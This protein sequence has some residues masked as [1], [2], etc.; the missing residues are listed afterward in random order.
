MSDEVAEVK[1][2]AKAIVKR[3]DSGE[4]VATS[5]TH[6]LEVANILEASMPIA[7]S[8]LVLSDRIL[9]PTIFILEPTRENYVDAIE[10]AKEV[11][12]GLYDAVA[13]VLMKESDIEE[14]YNFDKHFDC[15]DDIRR[16]H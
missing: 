9:S 7:D 13:Y 3:I 12:V 8:N 10:V 16:V 4:K 1:K 15:F 5:L 2:T 11:G 14:I 6:V